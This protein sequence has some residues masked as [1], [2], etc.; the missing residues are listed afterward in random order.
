LLQ[1]QG[2]CHVA[3][4]VTTADKLLLIPEIQIS[5]IWFQAPT[6]FIL[7][8]HPDFHLTAGCLI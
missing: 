3:G 6:G 7:H 5:I 2:V 1:S 8:K 4:R